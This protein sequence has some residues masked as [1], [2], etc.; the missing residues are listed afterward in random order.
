MEWTR[1]RTASLHRSWLNEV[2]PV[3]GFVW[4]TGGGAG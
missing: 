4:S 2:G 1:T 3:Y